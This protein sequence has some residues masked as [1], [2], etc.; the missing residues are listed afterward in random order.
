[1]IKN[2]L[3]NTVA[4]IALFSACN[5]PGAFSASA[6]SASVA[7]SIH[8]DLLGGAPGAI[9]QGGV[10]RPRS[11]R[12]EFYTREELVDE[13]YMAEGAVHFPLFA[14]I[15]P[16]WRTLTYQDL[17]NIVDDPDSSDGMRQ[18]AFNRLSFA[19]ENIRRRTYISVRDSRGGDT[20]G[21][22]FSM[23]FADDDDRSD[24]EN[25][26]IVSITRLFAKVTLWNSV[27]DPEEAT[28]FNPLLSKILTYRERS[29]EAIYCP[30]VHYLLKTDGIIE[31][32][33]K[34]QRHLV[35]KYPTAEHAVSGM[36]TISH[37]KRIKGILYADQA[38]VSELLILNRKLR[39]R[40]DLTD[41][42]QNDVVDADSKMRK[43]AYDFYAYALNQGAS[44]TCLLGMMRVIE[45]NGYSPTG[46][47]DDSDDTLLGL[48][49]RYLT[50]PE[51]D[52][53]V[54]QP[55]VRRVLGARASQSQR[56]AGSLPK[57]TKEAK[58]YVSRL[59]ARLSG[60]SAAGGGGRVASPPAGVSAGMGVG[61]GSGV[62]AAG[63]GFGFGFGF[64]ASSNS[65]GIRRMLTIDTASDAGV[66]GASSTSSA[67][68]VV[69]APLSSTR[70]APFTPDQRESMTTK[71]G[72]G[73]KSADIAKD[74]GL[75]PHVV[76]DFKRRHLDLLRH[77]PEYDG[78]YNLTETDKES[79]KSLYQ[80][81]ENTTT[82]AE[83]A[84]RYNCPF[85]QVDRVLH[86]RK[87]PPQQAEFSD[88]EGGELDDVRSSDVG[89]SAVP[90]KRERK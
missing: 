43:R 72:E 87:S 13:N 19:M 51:D 73:Q 24:E 71:F 8:D 27:M 55:I 69:R 29:G 79:I 2:F 78:S 58:D 59:K 42:S 57:P 41:L 66:T 50:Y 48:T 35:K 54:Q 32:A 12:P 9:V 18:A 75:K 83:I 65:G 86:K 16:R 80:R 33:L 45:E 76:N 34:L 31:D 26:A 81:D 64:G 22:I 47:K 4:A 88:D 28:C 39:A 21:E 10:I 89:A 1:M 85:S 70:S 46:D 30:Y 82:R 14:D 25:S 40:L 11:Y 68:D 20:D 90:L 63:A 36:P 49:N 38:R 53:R 77:N 60:T 37:P 5:V 6:S 3:L 74:L 17:K 84:A 56:L 61:F 23:F 15:G 67:S 44:K 52:G 7:R 62:A